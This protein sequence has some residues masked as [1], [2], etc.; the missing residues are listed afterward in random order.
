MI[1]PTIICFILQSENTFQDIYKYTKSRYKNSISV[2]ELKHNV[3]LLT[4]KKILFFHEADN[5]YTLSCRGNIVLNDHILYYSQ[6]IVRFFRKYCKYHRKYV[7]KAI[8]KEQKCLR[9]F[10]VFNK[11]PKCIICDKNLPLCLLETAHLK[12]RY[13]TNYNE[14]KDTNNVAFF[15]RYCHSLYDNGLIAVLN[16]LLLVSPLLN[17]YDLNYSSNKRIYS[18]NSNNM[19]Y[20]DYHFKNIF[21][22]INPSIFV[23]EE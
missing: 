6:I 1:D 18:Y 8:R 12:P 3:K 20:F 22:K 2:K 21:K 10:L 13:L 14:K 11:D 23:T 9:N 4:K 16:G 19:I 5:L 17:D 15:C 7:L